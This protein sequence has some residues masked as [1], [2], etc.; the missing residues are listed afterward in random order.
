MKS[1]LSYEDQIAI[2]IFWLTLLSLGFEI[3]DQ[4]LSEPGYLRYDGEHTLYTFSVLL[5]DDETFPEDQFQELL[6]QYAAISP[7]IKPQ[8]WGIEEYPA[9]MRNF[10]LTY[11][12]R[13]MFRHFNQCRTTN[14]ASDL[15]DAKSGAVSRSDGAERAARSCT[16]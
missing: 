4:D 15:S 5:R 13:F 9:Q 16:A 14:H 8:F 3:Q 7:E 1:N 2:F 6:A 10:T 12:R 11:V